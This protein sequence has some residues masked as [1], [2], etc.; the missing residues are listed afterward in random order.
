MLESHATALALGDIVAFGVQHGTGVPYPCRVAVTSE[1][2]VSVGFSPATSLHSNPS[3][4]VHYWADMTAV[5]AQGD[6]ILMENSGS[7]GAKPGGGY[8]E[9][10]HTG[11]HV[12]AAAADLWERRRDGILVN[13]FDWLAPFEKLPDA[14][15]P[16]ALALRREFAP[17]EVVL[18]AE[19]GTNVSK[20]GP[21]RRD[22]ST[23][24]LTLTEDRLA[25]THTWPPST[26]SVPWR[27]VQ[28]IKL[29]T[30]PFVTN[31]VAT[32]AGT[33]VKFNVN[34]SYA[35]EVLKFASDRYSL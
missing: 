15:T 35:R 10:T 18:D 12:V 8:R 22:E 33:E 7:R 4:F 25:F 27:S 3:L 24:F 21:P 2:L 34:K 14:L 6:S 11:D 32:S 13:R 23:G 29:R 17:G 9:R 28:R 5:R 26:W 1:A 20:S 30:G 31:I 16:Q 19:P